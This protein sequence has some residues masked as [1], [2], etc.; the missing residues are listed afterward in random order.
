MIINFRQGIVSYSQTGPAQFF[1]NKNGNGVDLFASNEPVILSFAH[2]QSNYTLIEPNSIPTAWTNLPLNVDSWLYWDLHTITAVRTFGFT[3]IP[4]LFSG[5][6]PLNP[7]NFQMWWDSTNKKWFEYQSGAW[8]EK[9]RVFAA[10]YNGL[11]FSPLGSGSYTSPYLGTQVAISGDPVASGTLL[12]DDD[13]P[14]RNKLGEFFTTESLLSTESTN[15]SNLRLESTFFVAE[16]DEVIPKYSVVRLVSSSKIK[17]AN[18]N[19]IENTVIGIATSDIVLGDTTNMILSGVVENSDWNWDDSLLGKPL[20]VKTNGELVSDDPHETSPSTFTVRQSPVAKVLSKT[21]IIFNQESF[22]SQSFKSY[23]SSGGTITVP[24]ATDQ[25]N[26]ISKLSL[27]AV[28]ANSP[29]VVGDNDPRLSDARVPLSH[30]HPATE[31]TVDNG[32][33]SVSTNVQVSLENLDTKKLSLANGGTVAGPTEFQ[34]T[35]RSTNAPTIGT[36]LTNKDYVDSLISGVVWIDPLVAT[37]VIGTGLSTPPLTP[38]FGDSYIMPAGTLNG[39]WSGFLENDIVEWSGTSWVKIWNL[40][41][42]GQTE[43]RIGIGFNSSTVPVGDFAGKKDQIGVY[44]V[45]GSSWSFEQAN[46]GNAVFNKNLTG[47]H[48]KHQYVKNPSGWVEFGNAHTPATPQAGVNWLV[49]VD[50]VN[51]LGVTLDTPPISPN[52]TDTYIMPAGTLNGAWSGFLENDIIIWKKVSGTLTWVK[53]G[54]LTDTGADNKK[55]FGIGFI[56]NSI[57]TAPLASNKHKIGEFDQTTSTWTYTSPSEFDAVVSINDLAV[58]PFQSYLFESNSW[59]ELDS[60]HQNLD[61]LLDTQVFNPNDGEYLKWDAALGKWVAAAVS[62]GG[63]SGCPVNCEIIT[64][65]LQTSGG[66]EDD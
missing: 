9:I 59:K 35:V 38:A 14:I 21:K 55:R 31:I 15:I 53:I 2:G 20:W 7:A 60:P 18:Y 25:I 48:N 58:H 63:A 40:T 5:N 10:K 39:D 41:D 49:P 22:A 43:V 46:D 17:L 23:N 12:F 54:S 45:S 65:Q 52:E 8:I 44:S 34:G 32:G 11:S 4:P 64:L 37:N 30:Q 29:I 42:N 3:T 16:A 33:E 28:D 66:G 56:G 27:A 47:V 50:V 51:L 1:L 62:A 36:D 19:S 57:D 24:V 61:D 6:K 26:G 13:E